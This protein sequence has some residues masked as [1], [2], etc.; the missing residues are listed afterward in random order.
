ML[1]QPHC[2]EMGG[3]PEPRFMKGQQS[4]FHN[5]NAQNSKREKGKGQ[6][7]FQRANSGQGQR[8]SFRFDSNQIESEICVEHCRNNK[9]L[10]TIDCQSQKNKM[11]THVD[12]LFINY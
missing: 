2:N 4:H 1:Q 11:Q 3:K 5:V 7:I 9:R 10:A 12:E 6:T 8:T